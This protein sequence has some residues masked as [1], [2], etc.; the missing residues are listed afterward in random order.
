MTESSQPT[1]AQRR[2]STRLLANT[3]VFLKPYTTQIIVA[4]VALVFTAALTLGLV[5]YV[6]LIVDRGFAAGS[7]AS[8][9]SAIIGFLVVA[10]LQAL[11]TFARFYWVSWL[12]ERVTA[13]IR[14]AVYRH[15]INLHPSYFE[16]N[17]SGEIQ[18]RITTDTTLIQS[19]IGS[20]AS[21]ALRNLLMMIG[22][23]VFL[24]ITNP[25]LTSVVLICI[26]LVIGPIMFFGRKVRRLSRDSQD[27]IANVGAYVG[28][29]IQQLKTVQAYNQ[30]AHN[31]GVFSRHVETAFKVAKARIF[32]RSILITLVMTLVFAALAVMIWVGGQDV[33]S[34]RMSAGELTAFVAYAVIVATAVG[35]VSQVISELQRAAGAMER[36]MELLEA[37]SLITAPE[38]PTELSGVFRGQLDFETVSFAYP[39]RPDSP[40]LDDVTLTLRPGESLALVGPSG[41]GKSTLLDLVLRFYDPQ[42]GRVL[43]DSVDVRQLTPEVLRSHIAI[44]S[45]QPALFTG[46]VLDNIRFGRP[47]A[48]LDEAR[49][50]AEAAFANEFIEQLPEGYNSYLGE[51]GVRLSGGQRQ[52]IAIAR[53]ILNDPEILLLDEATSALDAE[54]ERKVQQ[55]LEKLMKGRTSLIIAHRLAT[56]KNVD[57]IAVLEAGKLIAT[58]THSSLLTDCELYANLAQLQF[59]N[60]NGSKGQ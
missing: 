1:A 56:V 8:L 11:G 34:G 58:G 14:S 48:S 13:D 47:D 16:D 38:N 7:A 12:G 17:L 36:L 28:E 10:V 41:A 15:L 24:F 31:D 40:A 54:S 33:I 55:A 50:A 49:A 5:Q 4:S 22:G 30:Q 39:S 20:S 23:V 9:N 25:K 32:M 37:E 59:G 27:E 3:A 26:P 60:E 6:R 52:R 45:Q 21:I 44:V 43:L 42:S 29:S 51:A 46:S 53:A 57:R 35:A 19:V 18:S 2:S